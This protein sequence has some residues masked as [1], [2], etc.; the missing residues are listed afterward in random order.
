MKEGKFQWDEPKEESKPESQADTVESY[1]EKV[2]KPNRLTTGLNK[3]TGQRTGLSSS[4]IAS[5]ELVF[6][7]RLIPT[8]GK[9]KLNEITPAMIDDFLSGLTNSGLGKIQ[10]G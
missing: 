9:Y 3:S 7:K 10:S 8:F 6:N 4:S 5:Y 1:Y 2:F